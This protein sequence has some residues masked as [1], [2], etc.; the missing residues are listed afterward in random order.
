MSG[1][2][3]AD[4]KH[5]LPVAGKRLRFCHRA[6]VLSLWAAGAGNRSP[7]LGGASNA[8]SV[9]T[10]KGGKTGAPRSARAAGRIV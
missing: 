1:H 3:A 2:A 6:V 4:G 5:P 8:T 10:G 7:R 9:A